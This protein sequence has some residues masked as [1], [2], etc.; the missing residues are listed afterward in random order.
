MIDA[1]WGCEDCRANA[2]EKRVDQK[3]F[4]GLHT[5]GVIQGEKE[6]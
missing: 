3:T 1:S 5:I 2:A 4:N 6:R